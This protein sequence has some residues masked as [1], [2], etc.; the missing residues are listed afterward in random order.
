MT[1]PEYYNGSIWTLFGT[2][3]SIGITSSSSGLGVSGSPI[4]TNGTINLTLGSE[5]QA[6]SA[7]ASTGLI[8]RT[9]SNSYAGR[10]LTAST[11]INITN[12]DGI[13]G[14]P[15]FSVSIIDINT[16][17]TGFLA[18][19]RL[20]GYNAAPTTTF[21]KGDSSWSLV[22]I[23]NNTTGSLLPSR[24]SAYPSDSSLFLNG[25]GS[26]TTLSFSNFITQVSSQ[27]FNFTNPQ[28]NFDL[29]FPNSGTYGTKLRM[30]RSAFIGFE[31]ESTTLGSGTPIFNFNANIN[32]T[33]FNIFTITST[34]PQIIFN[35][36]RL[37]GLLD[38]TASTDAATKNYA[39]TSAL[40]PLRITGYPSN[41]GLFLNGLGSWV[42]PTFSNLITTSAS[43]Y[44]LTIN[45][46]NSAATAT[47]F[48]V[49]NNG[50]S[51][52]DF[53]F[54]TSTNEAYVW[55]YGTASL[56]FGTANTKRMQLLNNGTLDLLTNNLITTGN[57]SVQTGTL[58]GNNLA[59]YN[60]G[61]IVVLNP[62]A[63]NNNYITG[64]ANP[65]NS[66]DA[67]T[68]FYVDN[69]GG[70]ASNTINVNTTG[71]LTNW[72]RRS[73][74]T[75]TGIQVFGLTST[76]FILENNVGESAGIGFDGSTDTCTIWTAG[77]SG[78]YL[79]IQDE[80]ST[81]SRMAYVANTGVW[82]VVSSS[83]RKHSIKEKINNNILDRFLQ[84]SV[85]TYGY[86]YDDSKNFS[87]KKKARIKHKT[88]KMATGLVLE[89]L[90]EVF[91]NCIPDYYNE[92]FQKKD[93]NKK[94]DLT[95]EVKD[96][97]NC[98]I[99]YNTLLCY[100][101]MAFQEFVQ[102]TNNNILELKGKK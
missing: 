65:L 55:A 95:N 22:D 81:N 57:V 52:A 82:T 3:T 60:S 84:L 13:L 99:D 38:P 8:A 47:S 72:L 51:A 23:N 36:Y 75:T 79:N 102:K 18:I 98:G 59:A 70:L 30:G 77:D 90:F 48:F 1:L 25:S 97:A 2:V 80:D 33:I 92:L 20:A 67:A 4:T 9:G 46:T 41:S 87:E 44:S 71:G 62:L 15:T 101:I 31:F 26:W 53:G 14:N 69:S 10:T 7:F 37:S 66:Q 19:N 6:L 85:K 68:K 88:N 24:I 94:L 64:L 16:N 78:W 89:E 21:L 29:L 50:A 34:T 35:S 11:G 28:S 5:L 17:T 39:D 58:I 49:Q 42:A 63:M 76:A 54:N 74:N 83:K 93:P 96:T 91:P 73:I 56:K 45:N 43:T 40:S 27:T 86:K 12:G 32:N 61:S 100:F